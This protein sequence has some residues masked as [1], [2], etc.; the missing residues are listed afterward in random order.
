MDRRKSHFY[1]NWHLGLRIVVMGMTITI[2]RWF[3]VECCEVGEFAWRGNYHCGGEV[4]NDGRRDEIT[5]TAKMVN[6]PNHSHSRNEKA[7][8]LVRTQDPDI[9]LLNEL[10][11]RLDWRY[12]TTSSNLAFS[13]ILRR[14]TIHTLK[15][16]TPPQRQ[17]QIY[18]TP[19]RPESLQPSS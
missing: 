14:I 7:R 5:R 6:T 19:N 16:Q 10:V 11:K 2:L 9:D 18:H 8:E 1:I 15:S 12:H 13:C 17:N 3:Q 4:A